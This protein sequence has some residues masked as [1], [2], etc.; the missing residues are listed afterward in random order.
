MGYVQG[1]YFS[2]QLLMHLLT[3]K[4]EKLA[5]SRNQDDDLNDVCEEP[6][7]IAQHQ[8]IN[9]LFNQWQKLIKIFR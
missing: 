5:I 7:S 1:F 9:R 3:Q 4:E 6:E 2:R 8:K